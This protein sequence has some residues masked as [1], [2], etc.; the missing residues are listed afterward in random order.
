MNRTELAELFG[1]PAEEIDKFLQGCEIPLDLADYTDHVATLEGVKAVMIETKGKHYSKAFAL[2]KERRALAAKP[3]DVL[4]STPLVG[5]QPISGSFAQEWQQTA[6]GEAQ[7]L[8][9]RVL[10]APFEGIFEAADELGSEQK[11]AELKQYG[12]SSFFSEFNQLANDPDEARSFGE[13]QR[14]KRQASRSQTS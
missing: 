14:K 1:M 3:T 2:W 13:E 6:K 5:E 11:I 7:A 4:A 8:R 9:D 10:G 12:R